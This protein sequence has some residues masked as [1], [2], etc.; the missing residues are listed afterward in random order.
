[1]AID[2]EH[3]LEET[4]EAIKTFT[5]FGI[6]FADLFS[7]VQ[8]LKESG[9]ELSDVS[10]LVYG[11]KVIRF[12]E[13]R[14][15]LFMGLVGADDLIADMLNEAFGDELEFFEDYLDGFMPS[16]DL[17]E[18]LDGFEMDE[19]TIDDILDD[20]PILDIEDFS[21]LQP[22]LDALNNSGSFKN[23]TLSR[24]GQVLEDSSSLSDFISELSNYVEPASSDEIL[25]YRELDNLADVLKFIKSFAV[26]FRR[27]VMD[28]INNNPFQDEEI[29]KKKNIVFEDDNYISYDESPYGTNKISNQNIIMGEYPISYYYNGVWHDGTLL[30]GTF[31]LSMDYYISDIVEN[32]KV[33]QDLTK[34]ET[35]KSNAETNVLGSLIFSNKDDNQIS[36]LSSVGYYENG[37]VINRDIL[38]TNNQSFNTVKGFQIVGRN[39]VWSVAN[40]SFKVPS[41]YGDN[42]LTSATLATRISYHKDF[43]RDIKALYP[44]SAMRGQLDYFIDNQSTD[45]SR[46]GYTSSANLYFLNDVISL[47]DINGKDFTLDTAEYLEFIH[48]EE[49]EFFITHVLEAVSVTIGKSESAVDG[50]EIMKVTKTKN[51]KYKSSNIGTDALMHL[52]KLSV[53]L[54]LNKETILTFYYTDRGFLDEEM[55]NFVE[56]AKNL[57][58]EIVDNVSEFIEELF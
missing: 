20:A 50:K 45:F 48:S 15:E 40:L 4:G 2:I 30:N 23:L 33:L 13:A 44:S 52:D 57:S 7:V 9:N 18:D 14:R 46:W 54:Y 51:H 37:I 43:W 3:Y 42:I 29:F 8:I 24:L 27:V 21:Y 10:N 12:V 47:Y 17:F 34:Q 58:D 25:D 41:L 31:G 22:L 56:S 6:Q 1:M 26:D 19:N 38:S 39:V 35:I 28:F 32:T 36:G 16:I 11:M 55:D 5:T 53:L 49:F